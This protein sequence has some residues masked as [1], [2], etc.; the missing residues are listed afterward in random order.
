M[1]RINLG[2]LL[3][4]GLIMAVQTIGCSKPAAAPK[5]TGQPQAAA[6]PADDDAAEIAKAI[7]LLPEAE[8]S[9][10]LAQKVCPVGDGPLGSMGMPYKVT[11]NGRDVYLCCEG[12]K[13]TIEKD[14]DKYLA[15]LDAQAKP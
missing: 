13:E 4:V 2:T 3:T 14:P 6:A 1:A 12:C 9:V 15:K 10:A 5:A 7:A 11:V 8:Q